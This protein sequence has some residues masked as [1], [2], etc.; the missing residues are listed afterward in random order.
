MNLSEKAIAE[1]KEIYFKDFKIQLSDEEANARGIELIK[2]LS[3]IY[4]PIPR[5]IKN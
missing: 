2:F 1:F 5:Q 3:L 4:K